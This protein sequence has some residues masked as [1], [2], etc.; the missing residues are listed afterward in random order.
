[1][2][3]LGVITVLI[4]VAAG[5][6]YRLDIANQTTR[7][8][9]LEHQ[10]LVLSAVDLAPIKRVTTGHHVPFTGTLTPW[11]QT[12]LSATFAGKITQL[13]VKD[14]DTV[15]AGEV[16]ITLDTRAIELKYQ[17]AQAALQSK[18]LQV[19]QA[20]EKLQRLDKLRQKGFASDTKYDTASRQLAIYQAQV[21][22]AKAS[23]QLIKKQRKDA[24][25]RAP[26]DGK[27]AQRL[28]DRGEVVNA[29]QPLLKLVD[30][31]YLQLV[32]MVPSAD[33]ASVSPGQDA[34]F[35][36]NADATQV[37]HGKVARISPVAKRS[38]RR[39]PVYI[40]VDNQATP[41]PAGIFVRGKMLDSQPV[42]G[43]AVP[44][45]A[46]QQTANG[47][48]IFLVKEKHLQ[49]TPVEVLLYDPSHNRYI[50]AD[51]FTSATHLLRRPVIGLT[52]GQPV[53]RLASR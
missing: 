8:P 29:G 21:K 30:L 46:L 25:I 23:L 40:K 51:N 2:K 22:S 36:V 37:Y 28:A 5:V 12:T 14:G 39:V 31:H 33:I 13:N 32:A 41:L 49:A 11:Q 38:N 19:A 15:K 50:I 17:Q 3:W 26:F 20:R 16:L 45:S 53:T 34:Q 52:T 1:M 35:Q 18:K 27:I 44:A 9:P 43:V 42:T 7:N 6:F 10:P 47:W 24:V 48:Q 4:L